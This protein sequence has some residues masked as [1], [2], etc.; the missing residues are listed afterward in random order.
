M[1]VRLRSEDFAV[2]LMARP[3]REATI[4]AM[5]HGVVA[6]K[7]ESRETQC[8]S[9]SSKAQ[10]ITHQAAGLVTE[11]V[12]WPPAG[13]Q[14]PTA[15]VNTGGNVLVPLTNKSNNPLVVGVNRIIAILDEAATSSGELEPPEGAAS[16]EAAVTHNEN[17]MPDFL[18]DLYARSTEC[19][20][21]WEEQKV[22]RDILTQFQDVFVSPQGKMGRATAEKHVIDTGTNMPVK[23]RPYRMSSE[24]H[25][26]V[27]QECESMLKKGVIRDSKSPWSSPVVLV[28][29]KDGE[30]RFC[31]DY[32]RLNSLTVKDSYPLPIIQDTLGA[33]GGCKYFCTMDL[34]SGFWQIPVAER[35]KCKT[36]FATRDGL[37]E[38]NTMPF[39]LCNAPATFERLMEKVLVGLNWTIC[40]VYID[41]IVVAG[42]TIE[43]TVRRLGLVWERL[44][45]AGLKLKPSKC[46]LFR[47][48]V[49]FLG[50]TV[51]KNGVDTDPS[52]IAALTERRR[53]GCVEDIRS[54]LGLAGYYRDHVGGYAELVAPLT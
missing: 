36:A 43:E 7:I 48:E 34:A 40:L 20:P 29:K 33:L 8:S 11:T 13:V 2:R 32:R 21:D 3:V 19:M 18:E 14:A 10:A 39:G 52:K 45:A 42:P 1:I 49:A 17:E 50:H 4:D 26:V 27:E 44:R 46:T 28:T 16:S 5:S 41:D 9:G 47:P 22:V 37:Y 31:I 51:D 24:G 12:W 23:Q 30:V 54:F 25:K 35:D 38:F 15:L 53:P 6:C